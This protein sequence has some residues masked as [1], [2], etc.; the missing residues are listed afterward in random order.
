MSTSGMIH[1]CMGTGGL[2]QVSMS[3]SGLTRLP[4]GYQWTYVGAYMGM[5]ASR[6]VHVFLD[7]RGAESFVSG[8]L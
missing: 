7:E 8:Y 6:L 2:I 5:G 3:I 4:I 1:M